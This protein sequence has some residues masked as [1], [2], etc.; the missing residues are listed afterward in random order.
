[1]AND[2]HQELIPG[3]YYHIYN[4]AVASESIFSSKWAID[5]FRNRW[6]SYIEPYTDSIAYCLMPNHFHFMIRVKAEAEWDEKKLRQE[7]TQASA[8]LLAG[9]S[10]HNDFLVHQLVRAL[11][12]FALSYNQRK[13]RHG[14]VFQEGLKRICL[15]TESRLWWQLCYIHHNAI[16]HGFAPDYEEWLHSSYHDY[17]VRDWNHLPD[18]LQWL[19]TD[20]TSAKKHFLQEHE[21]FKAHWAQG[22]LDADTD[23]ELAA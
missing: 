10:S 18:H 13:K 5:G 19:G 1:M 21:Q 22:V 14:S 9:Q 8:K 7:R 2:Y 15:R 3:A 6:A 11:S 16:H 23:I 4:R 20:A 17:L 12:G